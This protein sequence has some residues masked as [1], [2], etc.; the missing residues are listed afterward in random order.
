M[1]ID[2]RGLGCPKPIILAEEALSKIE[3]GVVTVIVDNE[4]SMENLKRY[5]TRFGYYYEVE[6]EE[7]YWKVKIVKGYTCQISSTAEKQTKKD[8]LVIISSDVIGKDE[9]LGRVLMKAY[10]ET[11]IATRQLPQMIFL[12]NT[13]VKLST[14]DEEFI[15]LLK[16][17]EE[18][19]TEVFTCGTCLKYYNLEDSLKVGFRGT[20]N[21]F[22]EGMFDFN[23]TVWIG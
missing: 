19:G 8:L 10:F 9:K 22:V 17:I 23:K 6:N 20:T 12:M 18:M 14:I 4:G 21:H 5:A 1:E 2:A 7:N 16:K 13:A 3:E 15:S 11:I